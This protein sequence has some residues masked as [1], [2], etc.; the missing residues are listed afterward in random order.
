MGV[1]SFRQN[2]VVYPERIPAEH[3][4]ACLYVDGDDLASRLEWAVSNRDGAA[5]LAA[6]LRPAMAACDWSHLAPV[7]DRHL[8][9]LAG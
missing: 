5:S 9:E 3:H 8:A 6:E 2:R 7:Y 1:L 4:D